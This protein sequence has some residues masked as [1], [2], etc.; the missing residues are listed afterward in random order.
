MFLGIS[1]FVENRYFYS[2]KEENGWVEKTEHQK[3]KQYQWLTSHIAK[4]R[5]LIKNSY[6]QNMHIHSYNNLILIEYVRQHLP[7]LVTLTVGV[8]AHLSNTQ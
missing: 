6:N 3:I 4:Y 8:D 2:R 1:D 7:I 5:R